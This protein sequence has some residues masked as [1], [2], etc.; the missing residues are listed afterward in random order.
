MFRAGLLPSGVTQES[1]S[2]L[3]LILNLSRRTS[4]KT[5]AVFGAEVNS[6]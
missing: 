4:S 3:A 5:A 2:A 1:T 6:D